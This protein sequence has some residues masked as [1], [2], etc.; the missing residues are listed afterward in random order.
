[1]GRM[2]PADLEEFLT[3]PIIGVIATVRRD[4]RPYT[5]PVFWLWKDGYFW[6][7]GT[8][9][10]VW[11]KQLMRDPRCSLCIETTDPFPA[12]AEVD[13]RAEALKLPDF[14]IWPMHDELAEKYLGG[15]RISSAGSIEQMK[16]VWRTEPRMLFRITPEVWRAIDLRVYRGKRADQAYQAT[17]G[18]R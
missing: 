15:G 1:M 5:V 6:L 18:G 7:T 11:C 17:Q 8:T 13:G 10:R 3:K 9:T 14:D 4:G 2:K 12:H 16:A